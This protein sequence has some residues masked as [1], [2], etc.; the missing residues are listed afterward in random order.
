MP[1]PTIPKKLK[2][3][4]SMKTRRPSRTNPP[5]RCPFHHWGLEW[6][7]LTQMIIISTTM[8]KN[9]LEE[10][11]S[12]HSQQESEMQYLDAISKMTESSQFVSKAN[13]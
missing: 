2:L 13:K 11:S 8:G 9:P 5:K 1:L 10:W 4:S 6:V 7:N 12:H 3:I